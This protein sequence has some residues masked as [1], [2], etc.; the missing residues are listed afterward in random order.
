MLACVAVVHI[1]TYSLFIGLYIRTNTGMVLIFRTS[2][3]RIEFVRITKHQI[4]GIAL[5]QYSLH[6]PVSS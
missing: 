4:R 5:K 1:C 3:F 6:C 2:T